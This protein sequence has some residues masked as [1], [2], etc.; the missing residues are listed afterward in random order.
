METIPTYTMVQGSHTETLSLRTLKIM[1]RN[2]KKLYVHEFGFCIV[3][4]LMIF[5]IYEMLHR[6]DL[7]KK[8]LTN[9]KNH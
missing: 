6:S 1:L 5:G 3:L 9:Y 4:P 8:L 2:L 7:S